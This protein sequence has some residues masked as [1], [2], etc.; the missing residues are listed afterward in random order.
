M[1]TC[2]IEAT[3][4]EEAKIVAYPS[5]FPLPPPVIV[6]DSKGQGSSKASALIVVTESPIDT[7]TKL[8]HRRLILEAAELAE[9]QASGEA[10]D[11]VDLDEMQ[12]L[13]EELNSI[14]GNQRQ[15]RKEAPGMSDL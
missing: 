7:F 13:A 4:L 12:R 9:H 11:G 6:T 14:S 3:L 5:P 2:E 15:P 10:K 8:E 1:I